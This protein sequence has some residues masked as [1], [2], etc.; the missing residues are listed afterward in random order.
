M[1]YILAI[2]LIGAF[3]GLVGG[4]TGVKRYSH[5]TRTGTEIVRYEPI[6]RAT[7]FLFGA[8]S[9]FAAFG[10]WKRRK[11]GW[12]ITLVFMV[13]VV[14]VTVVCIP[15][16]LWSSWSNIGTAIWWSIQTVGMVY[17]IKWWRK[18]RD[19][20]EPTDNPNQPPQ[21]RATSGPV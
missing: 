3:S 20:F 12:Y 7:V 21:T 15:V 14:A 13:T 4:I 9:S 8:A 17:L 19:Q 10:V 5:S 2:L 1:K 11:F 18:Q 6:G 16:I